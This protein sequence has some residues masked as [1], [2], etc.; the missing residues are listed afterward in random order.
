MERQAREETMEQITAGRLTGE[1]T[2]NT[3][4]DRKKRAA[5]HYSK[6]EQQVE[7]TKQITR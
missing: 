7:R 3:V 4:G 1:R 2:E 6:K 5:E